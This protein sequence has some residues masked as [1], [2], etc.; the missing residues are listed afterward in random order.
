MPILT[1]ADAK[2]ETTDPLP[3]KHVAVLLGGP[4]A[5]REV[6][7]KSGAAVARGLRQ[8]G[9][10]VTEVDPDPARFALPPG[11][12]AVFIAL[13]GEFGED[14]T[15]QELLRARGLPYAG[16]S[17]ES[18]RLSFDKRLSKE[19]FARHG[20]PTPRYE[21]LG[22]GLPRT[23]PLPVVVKPPRQGSTIGIHRVFREEEWAPAVEDAHRY[24]EE[25]LVEEYIEGAELTVGVV[26]G[27][28]LPVI[29]IRAPDGYYDY[30]AKYTK[31]KTQYLVP[32]PLEPR[33]TQL[34]H[35][36]AARTFAVLGCRGM[37]RVDLRLTPDGRPFVLELN[38]I[39]GFTETSL[40][41]MAARAAGMEFFELCDRILRTAAV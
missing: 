28:V 8:A 37:A 17:P 20:I 39:P 24:D 16:S 30:G 6:S 19:L 25:I 27:E 4:S 26:N 13:H 31:G 14:G 1:R 21:V 11:V 7:L 34:C 10:T 5:E 23:L 32:A 40:L 18:S 41:P 15:V 36:L 2:P 3:F 29:E 35:E 33:K 12:D 22:P 9:Y 38:S